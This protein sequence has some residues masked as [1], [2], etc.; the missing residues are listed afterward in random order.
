M[1]RDRQ[2]RQGAT[3][4]HASDR[5]NVAPIAAATFARA[6]RAL[7][8]RS[9]RANW[10][11][12]AWLVQTPLQKEAFMRH[13]GSLSGT[14]KVIVTLGLCAFS[15]NSL[16]GEPSCRTGGTHV[17]N[18]F[19][20]ANPVYALYYGD[21]ASYLEKNQ[22]QFREGG[23]AIRCAAALSRGFMS[24]ALRL[25]D[26]ADI[27]RRQLLDAR[28]R[29]NGIN[30]GP[31]QPTAS[32]MLFQMSM[33]LSRLARVLPA[34]S[35]GDFT[36]WNTP[37]NEIEQMQLLGESVLRMFLQDP[38]VKSML[39]AVEPLMREAAQFDHYFVLQA[40]QRLAK[41]P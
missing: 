14:F 3:L 18:A 21:L 16:A 23:D 11:R 5:E 8:T 19:V 24:D 35:R 34:A 13:F 12:L 27:Q 41:A 22:A 17:A 31:Q 2:G 20:L 25:Y 39:V 37:T 10:R 40:T 9:M 28:L 32:G 1:A 38:T 33:S 4:I 29:A 7:L 36:P 26:P 15:P 30:P 6:R